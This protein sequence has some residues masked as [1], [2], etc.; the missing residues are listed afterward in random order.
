V[1]ITQGGDV[2]RVQ[3]SKSPA[4]TAVIDVIAKADV[5]GRPFD[6]ERESK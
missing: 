2:T 1:L 4:K 6:F 5:A 3:P